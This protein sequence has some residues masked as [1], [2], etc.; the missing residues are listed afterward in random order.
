M[1]FYSYISSTELIQLGR[2]VSVTNKS[3]ETG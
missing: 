1:T 3:L 2:G